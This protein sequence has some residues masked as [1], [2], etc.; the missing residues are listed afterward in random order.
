MAGIGHPHMCG[1]S[2][3][4]GWGEGLDNPHVCGLKTYCT[5]A[6]ERAGRFRTAQPANIPEGCARN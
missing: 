4:L 3:W 5:R 6:R 2:E 1:P